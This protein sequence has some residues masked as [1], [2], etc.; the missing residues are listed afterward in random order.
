MTTPSFLRPFVRSRETGWGFTLLL[1]VPYLL[2]LG[3]MHMH[4]EMWRDEI[5]FWTV[6][7]L[8]R[9]FWDLVVGDRVY[10]GHPPLWYWY[11]HVCTWFTKDAAGIQIATIIAAI[12]AAVLFV[13]FA[14]FPRYLKVLLLCSFYIGYEWTVMSRNY[15]LGWLFSALFC[16]LY[17]PL[18]V[19][20]LGLGLAIALL[21][22]SS[23]YGL[24]LAFLT[25]GFFLLH[26]PRLSL[27]PAAGSAPREF[28]LTTSPGFLVAIAVSLAGI[29]F[30]LLTISPPDP[31]PFSPAFVFDAIKWSALPDMAYRFVAGNLPWRLYEMQSYWAMSFT[32]WETTSTWPIY[33]GSGLL[34]LSLLALY[35]SWRIMLIYFAAVATMEMFQQARH[36][37]VSRHWGH[38]FLA[39]LVACWLLRTTFPRRSHWLS[40]VVLVGLL[41]VQVQ[42]FVIATVLDTRYPFSGARETA[43]FIRRSG[44]QDLPL[45]GGPDYNMSTVTGYLRRPFY[46]AET[47]EINQT[48]V[49]HARR[50]EFSSSELMTRAVAVSQERKSPV[51]LVVASLY[52]LPAPPTGVK[53]EKLFTSKN[54]TVADERFDVYKLDAN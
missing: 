12:T 40:T 52:G 28:T 30:C 53:L 15:V 37:G 5:H 45:V 46:A 27:S 39:F 35:P 7:R 26:Q 4:H 19:R 42:P 3:W 2:F 1:C 24:V 29:L 51:V 9:G 10:D 16:A 8:A 22:L 31:N 21:S 20:H 33:V 13:R 44:L 32:F 18:R 23:F 47:E 34:L 38:Y 11:L 49:F 50:R 6:A 48:V 36:E 17:H 25:L 14:P 43:A 54:S 41:G